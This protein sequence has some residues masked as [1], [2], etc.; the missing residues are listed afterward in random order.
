[1]T[2]SEISSELKLEDRRVKIT[3]ES[4]VNSG[5]VEA[6]GTGRGKNYM[7]SSEYYHRTGNAIAYVRQKGIASIR[8][9]ELVMQLADANGTVCRAEVSDFCC[10]FT[11][12]QAY[13]VL[14]HLVEA[15]K[16][17]PVGQGA[18]AKYIPKKQV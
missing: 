10:I 16:L 14:K 4:L 1:M 5:I 17:T 15:G 6:S 11:A 3:L 18:G 13:R 12:P 2:S 7:L 8:Y 9:D